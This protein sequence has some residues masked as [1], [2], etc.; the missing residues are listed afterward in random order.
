MANY[1]CLDLVNIMLFQ[2]T[3]KIICA[4][5]CHFWLFCNRQLDHRVV[6]KLKQ[7]KND[8]I[9][10]GSLFRV[11]ET[12]LMSHNLGTETVL[13]IDY[14]VINLISIITQRGCVVFFLPLSDV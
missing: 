7:A 8:A 14:F 3:Y 6:L 9:V 12:I 2:L 1:I 11:I 10:C 4:F 5:I 13:Y